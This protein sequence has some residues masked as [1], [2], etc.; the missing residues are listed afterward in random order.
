MAS[1]ETKRR[2]DS[3]APDFLLGRHHGLAGD[4]ISADDECADTFNVIGVDG[5]AM[6]DA[7]GFN[8]GDMA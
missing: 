7:F 1:C 3:N 8:S 6:V 4:T 5:H 2:L